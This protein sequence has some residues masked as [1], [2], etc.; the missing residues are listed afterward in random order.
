MAF[1][2]C[3]NTGNKL[4]EAPAMSRKKLP[5]GFIENLRRRKPIRLTAEQ[6]KLLRS[7]QKE[8]PDDELLKNTL[9][10]IS[11]FQKDL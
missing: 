9:N 7:I 8:Y 5:R 6:E 1:R 11:E 2:L 10:T 3:Y 4:A